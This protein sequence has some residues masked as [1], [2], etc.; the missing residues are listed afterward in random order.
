MCICMKR[1]K[2][3]VIGAG[4][5]GL[6]YTFYNQY[7]DNI[8]IIT[9][10]IG[11]LVNKN[12]APRFVDKNKFTEKLLN[13]L[14]I[15]AEETTVTAACYDCKN[16]V[17]YDKINKKLS[18]QIVKQKAGWSGSY[19]VRD[20]FEIFNVSF[21]DIID[22]IVA[23]LNSNVTLNISEVILIDTKNNF[24][25]DK[26]ANRYEFSKLIST[27]PA[28]LFRYLA[29][30]FNLNKKLLYKPA[31]FVVS[32]KLLSQFS[33]MKNYNMLYVL[34]FNDLTRIT[35]LKYFYCYEFVNCKNLVELKKIFKNCK[36][37]SYN[38]QR[39]AYIKDNKIND[40]QS[41]NFIGRYAEWLSYIKLQHIVKK[42]LFL[43]NKNS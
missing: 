10:N 8:T 27:M 43:S 1:N 19:K 42:S 20:N 28:T 29:Y 15:A 24:V 39:L 41:I 2:I 17:L 23:K 14:N 30:N 25:V 5:A 33:C 37:L 21:N 4:V 11:G 34:N 31:T 3:V 16:N 7:Y 40:T 6:I 36:I 13:D 9:E 26:N 38:V 22:K 35:K 18:K 32:N 12:L